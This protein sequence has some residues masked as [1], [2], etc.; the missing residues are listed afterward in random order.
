MRGAFF[1]LTLIGLL[2]AIFLAMRDLAPEDGVIGA[3]S[4]MKTVERAHDAAAA[5][6]RQHQ[7]LQQRV[8][9]ATRD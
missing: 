5:V 1:V 6:N 8:D 4:R 3:E 7:E 2:V 9:E